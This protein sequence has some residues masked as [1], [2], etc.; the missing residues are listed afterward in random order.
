MM[1]G[2]TEGWLSPAS[3]TMATAVHHFPIGCAAGSVAQGG[4]NNNGWG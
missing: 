2:R 4:A 3:I 1:V